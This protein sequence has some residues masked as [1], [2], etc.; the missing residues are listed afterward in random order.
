M[1]ASLKTTGKPGRESG[2]DLSQENCLDVEFRSAVYM[3]YVLIA[4]H[5]PYQIAAI[6]LS[7]PASGRIPFGWNRNASCSLQDECVFMRESST[8]EMQSFF[9]TK[10]PVKR[11]G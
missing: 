4:K 2:V 10:Y 7:D 8:A 9:I 5:F 6:R 11:S 1:G 3:P